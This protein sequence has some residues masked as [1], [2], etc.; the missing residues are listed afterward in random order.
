MKIIV[1]NVNPFVE[2][3]SIMLVDDEKNATNIGYVNGIENLGINIAY[4]CN[5]HKV[6]KVRLAGAAKYNTAIAE[7]IMAAAKANYGISNIEVE[8][9]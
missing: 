9:I 6:K 5:S 8:V 7:E 1:C 4:L 3:H 2:K